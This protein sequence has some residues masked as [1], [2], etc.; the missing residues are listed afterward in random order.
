MELTPDSIIR[1]YKL[2]FETLLNFPAL[3]LTK[4]KF[5]YIK[6]ANIV[7]L[8]KIK[9]EVTSRILYELRKIFFR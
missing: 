5:E 9:L 3:R 7:F 4:K 6:V 1:D 2:P 8:E